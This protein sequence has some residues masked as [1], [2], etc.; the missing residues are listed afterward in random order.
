METL[1]LLA[2]NDVQYWTISWNDYFG[3]K[4]YIWWKVGGEPPL[5]GSEMKVSTMSVQSSI[6]I[7]S[8][9]VTYFKYYQKI[10]EKRIRC[11]LANIFINRQFVAPSFCGMR[12]VRDGIIIMN[13]F[14]HSDIQLHLLPHGNVQCWTCRKIHELI[15][16]L[17]LRDHSKVLLNQTLSKHYLK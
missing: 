6:A 12:L 15:S 2:R 5:I 10:S 8:E 4:K 17:N 16:G 7:F 14:T 13:L 1:P 11:P 9:F 3:I